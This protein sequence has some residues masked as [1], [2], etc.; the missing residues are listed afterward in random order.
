[1]DEKEIVACSNCREHHQRLE[2]YMFAGEP[3]CED[4][5]Q[6]AIECLEAEVERLKADNATLLVLVEAS[7]DIFKDLGSLIRKELFPMKKAGGP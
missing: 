7:K 5:C 2:T 1:V 3:V 6:G 4:C